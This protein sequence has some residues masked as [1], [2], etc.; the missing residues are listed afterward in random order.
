MLAAT[1]SF[2]FPTIH[3]LLPRIYKFAPSVI[4]I[5]GLDGC[6]KSS[7]AH[8]VSGHTQHIVFSLDHFL[9]KN[10]GTYADH[11]DVAS[12]RA[13]SRDRKVIIEGVCLLDIAERADLKLDLLVYVQ[14]R[15]HGLW[16]DEDW[17]GLNQDVDEYIGKLNVAV[18]F[19]GGEETAGPLEDLST[20]IIRYHHRYLP[21]EKADLTYVWN[22]N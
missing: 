1:L 10:K 7:I 14:R 22:D 5:D 8:R 3:S 16:A 6:R 12:L 2:T 4:G 18:S 19:L 17:L 21:H 13:E 11:I 20:E 9:E 15:H